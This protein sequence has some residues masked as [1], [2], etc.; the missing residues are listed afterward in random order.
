MLRFLDANIF[1]RFL[2]RDD[3]EKAEHCRRLFVQLEAGAVQAWTSES[4]IAEIVFVLASPRQYALSHEHI[5]DLLTPLL[6][7]RGLHVPYKPI[8]LE[9]LRDFGAYRDLDF[10]DALTLAHMRRLHLNELISYD[11][12]FDRFGRITRI[13]PSASV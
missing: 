13:E 7:L 2:T 8:F 11:T 5:R 6:H 4:V 12:D 10:E 9:A 3:E 1:L